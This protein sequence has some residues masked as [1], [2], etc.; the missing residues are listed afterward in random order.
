[1]ELTELRK[2]MIRS[3]EM[4]LLE[5]EMKMEANN[6][7]FGDDKYLRECKLKLNKFIKK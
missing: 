4:K 5:L 1:M 6:A 2:E 7:E 3:N